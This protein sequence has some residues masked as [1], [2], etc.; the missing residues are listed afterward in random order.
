MGRWQESSRSSDPLNFV[1]IGCEQEQATD[2]RQ[3]GTL[4]QSLLLSASKSLPPKQAYLGGE[5]M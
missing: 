4:T 3:Q 2:V 1:A 5:D